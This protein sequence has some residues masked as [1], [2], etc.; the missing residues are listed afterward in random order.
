M[1]GGTGDRR[2]MGRKSDLY[3][4]E[5]LLHRLLLLLDA[6]EEHADK[7]SSDDLVQALTKMRE[8]PWPEYNRGKGL[9]QHGLSR[10]LKPYAITPADVRFGLQ[11]RKGYHRRQ[12]REAWVRYLDIDPDKLLP[13]PDD[14]VNDDAPGRPRLVRRAPLPVPAVAASA[15]VVSFGDQVRHHSIRRRRSRG[16]D[17]GD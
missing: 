13:D 8:R 9:T 16:D 3:L 7:V 11:V 14:A 6:E 4:I 5:A 2:R 15:K 17:S 12:F 10:L 1:E